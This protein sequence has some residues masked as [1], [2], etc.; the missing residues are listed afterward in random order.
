MGGRM[1]HIKA[2]QGEGGGQT[3]RVALALSAVRRAPLH[4]QVIRAC[5]KVPGL[6]AQHLTAVTAL[7]QICGAEIT[8]AALGSQA[9]MLGPG[10]VRPGEYH[11]DI[12]TAGSTILVLQAVLL[13]LALARGP[14]RVTLTGGTHVPWSPPADY[15]QDVLLPRLEQIGIRARLDVAR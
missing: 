6:Q 10:P 14:S 3:L 5:R 8:G 1:I 12:G 2:D 13:P 9:L 4:L 11:F 15:L 7:G